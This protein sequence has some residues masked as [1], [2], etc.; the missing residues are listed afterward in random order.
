MRGPPGPDH[1][2][3]VLRSITAIF[4]DR[5]DAATTRFE[6]NWRAYLVEEGAARP[7]VV[8]LCPVCAELLEGED[9]ATS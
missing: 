5:C 9:E 6:R 4:C 3:T 8:V 2:A 7:V 1:T